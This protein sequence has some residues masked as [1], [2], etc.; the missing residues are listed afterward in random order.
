MRLSSVSFL[1]GELSIEVT[2]NDRIL[3]SA[4]HDQ[5]T[6]KVNG[7]SINF[8]VIATADVTDIVVTAEMDSSGNNRINLSRVT[9]S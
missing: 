3:V 1:D 4:A 8:G 5:T 2:N 7:Q 6:V 9:P